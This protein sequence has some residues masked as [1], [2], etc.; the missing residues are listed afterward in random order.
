MRI[1]PYNGQ[2]V[3]GGALKYTSNCEVYFPLIVEYFHKLRCWIVSD[4]FAYYRLFIDFNVF[5]HQIP[6][7][8]MQKDQT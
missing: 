3:V 5:R 2:L 8:R 1:K 7:K 4:S 6:V